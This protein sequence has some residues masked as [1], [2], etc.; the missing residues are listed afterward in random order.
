[1]RQLQFKIVTGAEQARN[2]QF[3]KCDVSSWD[4]QVAMFK[5]AIANSPHQSCDIVLANAGL[6]RK[7]DLSSIESDE[8]PKKP[9]LSVF[10]INING[11]CYTLKLAMHYFVRQPESQDRDRCL[12]MTDSLAGYVDQPGAIQYNASKYAV[13]SLMRSFRHTCTKQGIRINTISP[14]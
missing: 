6:G 9:D 8:E 14:W 4:D 7:D 13:R 5:K 10:D 1:M 11:Y 3:T 2:A 12:I